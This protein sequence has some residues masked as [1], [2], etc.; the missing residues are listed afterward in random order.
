MTETILDFD[1]QWD[2][3]QPQQTEKRFREMLNSAVQDNSYRLQLLTQLARAQGLQGNFDAA[4]KTL[5]EVERELGNDSVVRIRY[6][7]ERGR[8]FNSRTQADVA[9]PLF[10]KAW[11]TAQAVGEDFYAVDAA[12]MLAIIETSTQQMS[13]N[14]EA[15]ALAEKSSSPR[16]RRWLASLYNNIGWTYHDAGQYDE[17]LDIF[18]KALDF[19]QQRGQEQESRI[20]RWCIARTLRSLN[21]IPEALI[22]LHELETGDHDGY[23]DEELAECLL[24]SGKGDNA[25]PYFAKAYAKLSLDGWL[26]ANEPSRLARLKE[27]GG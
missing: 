27:L 21:R 20:A 4:H 8:V 5:D 10:L 1:E 6:L 25:R 2:Y 3:G 11:E 15:V 13:W 22:I 19:R 12:H 26:S 23:V 14:L 7:L 18:K 24:I 17:A 16:A 9:R